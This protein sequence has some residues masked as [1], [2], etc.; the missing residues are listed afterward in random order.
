MMQLQHSPNSKQAV[1]A[2]QLL[3]HRRWQLLLVQPGSQLHHS[4]CY[5]QA[6]GLT[7]ASAQQ[8]QQQQQQKQQKQ[9]KQEWAMLSSTLHTLQRLLQL[10]L[11][12]LLTAGLLQLCSLHLLQGIA[13]CGHRPLRQSGAGCSSSR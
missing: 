10:L 7:S 4:S 13:A 1:R 12:G 3:C 6:A 11:P 9:Q 5:L 8:Q 2:G